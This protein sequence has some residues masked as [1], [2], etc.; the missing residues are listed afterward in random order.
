[1]DGDQVCVK[2]EECCGNHSSVEEGFRRRLSFGQANSPE[3][4]GLRRRSGSQ[5]PRWTA[6]NLQFDDNAK[7]SRIWMLLGKIED[8]NGQI[9]DGAESR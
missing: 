7:S 3:A 1:T 8:K 2:L 4:Q 6:I 5:E 9:N